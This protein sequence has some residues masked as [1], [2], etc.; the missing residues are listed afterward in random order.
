VEYQ[1][2]IV[3]GKMHFLLYAG[4]YASRPP[5]TQHRIVCIG[6]RQVTSGSKTKGSK[7]KA[8]VTGLIRFT[9]RRRNSL[10]VG[11]YTFRSAIST[12]FGAF[13]SLLRVR[14]GEP[15]QLSSPF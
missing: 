7:S 2:S 1:H 6:E 15:R 3:R 4:R 8:G 5:I 12:V 14:S 11:P 10:T 9:A 13:G